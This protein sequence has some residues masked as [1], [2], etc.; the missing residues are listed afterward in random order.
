MNPSTLVELQRELQKIN[1]SESRPGPFFRRSVYAWGYLV[2]AFG[3]AAF[4]FSYEP[5]SSRLAI[6]LL[7]ILI[8][9]RSLYILVQNNLNK[10]LRPILES[11][12]HAP[13]AL[14]KQEQPPAHEIVKHKRAHPKRR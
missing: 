5:G 6:P 13:E 14:P 4:W 10:R 12:L 7:A 2:F 1:A 11:L 8:A 9:G 3:L